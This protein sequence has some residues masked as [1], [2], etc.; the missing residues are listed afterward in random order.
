MTNHGVISGFKDTD[1][2]AGHIPYEVRNESGDW[3][4]Y[5]VRQEKQ[6]YPKFDTQACVSFSA[7]NCC[8]MQIK[9]QTGVEQNFSDRFLA[10]LSGTTRQGNWLYIVG[11][12]LRNIGCVLEEEWP[13]PPEP[14]D[15]NDYYTDIPQFII[16]RAKKQ[17]RDKYEVAYER[18]GY[19]VD[20]ETLKRELK[21]APLWTVIPG[22]AVAM[23]IVSADEKNFTYFDTYDP[24]IKTK[25]I[26]DLE[27][28][29]KLVLTMKGNM[30]QTKVALSKDGHTV[31]K[32]VP[33][34][35]SWEE[36]LKQS[37][38]EGIIVPNPIPPTS[39]L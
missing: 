6:W 12:T 20:A 28:V 37:N 31:Y 29:W 32:A 21:H 4:P 14:F 9:Q 35:T 1:W 36:F 5:L 13:T 27:S 38:V 30:N 34:A 16:D 7:L 18:V 26:A 22:H 23:T 2:I 19:K 25:P 33:I 24:H 3:T 15:W 11:D 10:K 17:W 8:E 39:D